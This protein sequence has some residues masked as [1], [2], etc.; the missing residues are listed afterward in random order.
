VSVFHFEL[1]SGIQAAHAFNLSRTDLDRIVL[2]AWRRGA[3]VEFG[4]RRWPP[5]RAQLRVYEGRVLTGPELSFGRGWTNAVKRGEDV[6][7][8]LLAAGAA[9]V[10]GPALPTELDT[11]RREVLAQCRTGPIGVHEV[12]RLTNRWYPERRASERLALAES[13]VWGLLHE[14]LIVLRQA[15]PDGAGPIVANH[16]W[17]G[18]LLDWRTWAEAEP[19]RALIET[20]VS[21]ADAGG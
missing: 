18:V 20:A 8:R 9:G 21:G 19:P 13:A 7:D 3:V 14:Q 11:L 15:S 6:T 16:A 12:L 5:D 4:D 2:D 17:E 10:A 1:R